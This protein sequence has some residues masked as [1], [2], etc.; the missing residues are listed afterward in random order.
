MPATIAGELSEASGREELWSILQRELKPLGDLGSDG[1]VNRLPHR[2]ESHGVKVFPSKTHAVNQQVAANPP[3]LVIEP[4]EGASAEAI[5]A[6]SAGPPAGRHL[7][8]IR[9]PAADDTPGGGEKSGV[10][11]LWSYRIGVAAAG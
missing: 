3:A 5:S 10:T 1:I 2:L 7:L 8:Q 11:T 4:L 6:A 9:P